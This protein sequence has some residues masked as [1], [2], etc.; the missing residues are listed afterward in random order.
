MTPLM[1]EDRFHAWSGQHYVLMLVTAVGVVVFI[2][3]GRS[4]RGTPRELLARR[5]F[6]TVCLV[7]IL[8]MQ[9]YWLTPGART[10]RNSVPLQLSDLADYAA[11]FALW[12]RG[13]RTSA[14]TYYIGL[15]LTLMA[16]ITP[17]LTAPFPT[18]QWW[19]F[20]LRHIFVVWAAVYLV[21]GLGKRPTW[22]LYWITV[23][24]VLVWAGVAQTFNTITGANYGYLAR[25]PDAA[26]PLDLLGPW[27][28][29]V[30]GA[31][32]FLMALWAAVFTLPWELAKRRA[33]RG[34]RESDLPA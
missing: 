14:F 16:V 1:D 32:S 7:V 34:P 17:A 25:T 27:P 12:T 9:I 28:W 5:G 6:A 11:V 21:W 15:T 33:A 31:M 3:W 10:I 24:A 29:Y 19:G 2:W 23:A 4:H 20:W 18:T 26:T 22:R 8:G 30:F 13:S